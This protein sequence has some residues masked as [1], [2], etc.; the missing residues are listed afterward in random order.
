MF[1]EALPVLR[2]A[3]CDVFGDGSV[4]LERVVNRE[5]IPVTAA[6]HILSGDPA[7][8]AQA[9]ISI[10]SLGVTPERGDILEQGNQRYAVIG[11]ES[12]EIFWTLSLRLSAVMP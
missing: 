11:V 12:D 6:V 8:R 9:L 3:I 10:A 2:D 7:V 1:A 4:I 5:R